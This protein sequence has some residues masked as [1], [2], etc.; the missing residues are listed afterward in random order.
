[1]I[2]IVLVPAGGA[3]HERR[4]VVD[5]DRPLVLLAPH[6]RRSARGAGERDHE[7]VERRELLLLAATRH[8]RA[9]HLGHVGDRRH[10]PTEVPVT[11]ELVDALVP[12]R[13]IDARDLLDADRS[14]VA[15]RDLNQLACHLLAGALEHPA[16]ARMPIASRMLLG[17]RLLLWSAGR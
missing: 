14:L 4:R 9:G 1:M 15:K 8:G 3:M 7:R 6:I 5:R 12:G 2:R 16:V 10:L 13:L 17:V 11:A